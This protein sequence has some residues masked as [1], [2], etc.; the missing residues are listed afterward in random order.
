MGKPYSTDLRERVI[1]RVAAGGDCY[2][3]RAMPHSIGG[4]GA[5]FQTGARSD[6][7][8]RPS[9][10]AFN[11]AILHGLAWRDVMPFN[12]SALLPFQD[13]I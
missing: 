11:E 2:R 3:R 4:H 6:T 9:V 5:G 8:S 7:R 10:E 1:R 13:R 12:F